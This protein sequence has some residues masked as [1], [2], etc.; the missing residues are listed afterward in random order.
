L[1]VAIKAVLFYRIYYSLLAPFYPGEFDLVRTELMQW[2]RSSG[3]VHPPLVASRFLWLCRIN[4][5]PVMLKEVSRDFG[6]STGK[7][8]QMMSGT[9]YVPALGSEDYIERLARQL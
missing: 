4:K 5:V 9:E 2:V 7:L 8:M 3:R 1:T 6:I